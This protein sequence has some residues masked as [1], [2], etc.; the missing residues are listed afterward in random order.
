MDKYFFRGIFKGF[1]IG[2]AITGFFVIIFGTYSMLIDQYRR[3][4]KSI[5]HKTHTYTEWKYA[6]NEMYVLGMFRHCLKCEHYETR[7]IEFGRDI[8]TP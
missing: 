3:D 4:A 8:E 7:R 1:F 2:C 5:E 6:G